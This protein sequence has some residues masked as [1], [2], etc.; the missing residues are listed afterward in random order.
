MKIDARIALQ[1]VVDRL[2]KA[3]ATALYFAAVVK[4]SMP[5]AMK[6]S[7]FFPAF[8]TFSSIST[9]RY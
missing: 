7:L 8:D 3:T 2:V 9:N 1:N 5:I 4:E 6:A